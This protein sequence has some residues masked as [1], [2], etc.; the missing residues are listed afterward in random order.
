M[1]EASPAAAVPPPEAVVAAYYEAL[2]AHRFAAAWRR[3]GPA[4]RASFGAF[5]SWRD[6]YATTISSRPLEVAVSAAGDE[7]AVEHLLVT[8]DRSPCGPVRRRFA[9][10]WRLVRTSGAWRAASLSAVARSGA[11]TPAACA[12]S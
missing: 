9:V 10:S 2:D 1:A 7:A 8:E 12:P 3:L 6:G 5:R 11:G 4:V